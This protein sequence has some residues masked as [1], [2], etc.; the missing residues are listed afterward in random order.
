MRRPLLRRRLGCALLLRL[1]R[2][3]WCLRLLL[4]RLLRR[5]RR[6]LVRLLLRGLR[7]LLVRWPLLRLLLTRLLRWPLL[8]RRRLRRALLGVWRALRWLLRRL[9]WPGRLRHA[10]T[11]GEPVPKCPMWTVGRRSGS[12]RGS[13]IPPSSPCPLRRLRRRA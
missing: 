2:L 12:V 9:R 6:L 7:L 1:T 5:S 13:V 8:L 4:N 10:R 11:S 3:L